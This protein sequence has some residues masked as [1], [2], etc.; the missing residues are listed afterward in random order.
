MR[1]K[2]TFE[3]LFVEKLQKFQNFITDNVFIGRPPN[4]KILNRKCD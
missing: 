1:A 4:I 3:S 2:K